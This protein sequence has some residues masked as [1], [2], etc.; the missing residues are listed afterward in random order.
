[1]VTVSFKFWCEHMGLP[2]HPT[3]ADSHY[4]E[5]RYSYGAA[6]ARPRSYRAVY[7]LWTVGSSRLLLWGDP[8]YAARFARSCQLGDGDG[9]EV[10]GPVSNKGYANEAGTWRLFA[11]HSYEV[12]RWEHERSWYFY[13]AFGRL[14][15]NPN[16]NAE[17][18]QRELRH[19][20]GAAAA[21]I[22]SAYRH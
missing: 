11:D 2:Y 1:R 13:L 10:F 16:A 9:F 17:V 12:G 18:W 3:V 15:Y 5:S 19:R 20:F 8:E 21:D 4:R 22:E 14:G 7:Q 6:L